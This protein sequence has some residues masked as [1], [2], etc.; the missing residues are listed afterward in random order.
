MDEN[1][2]EKIQ[3]NVLLSGFLQ[4]GHITVSPIL[5]KSVVTIQW[6][7]DQMQASVTSVTL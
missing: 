4:T 5:L 1:L 3:S 2:C 6:D 7:N